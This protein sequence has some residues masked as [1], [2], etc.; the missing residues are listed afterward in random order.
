M[1][2]GVIL[3]VILVSVAFS[4]K[5]AIGQTSEPVRTKISAQPQT[6]SSQSQ[7]AVNSVQNSQS[8]SRAGE[9]IVAKDS[10]LYGDRPNMVDYTI[11]RSFEEIR[12]MAL[13]ILDIR[14]SELQIKGANTLTLEEERD[15]IICMEENQESDRFL[16][17]LVNG[18]LN[19]N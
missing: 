9:T 11:G 18:M 6:Q 4:N 16:R 17:K 15:G 10:G 1:K 2:I 8:T 7:I 5:A 13:S 14:I 3:L 12:M 19:Q